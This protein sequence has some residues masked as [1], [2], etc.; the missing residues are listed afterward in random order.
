MICAHICFP[1]IG[2][3]PCLQISPDASAAAA[4]RLQKPLHIW[5]TQCMCFRDGWK[6][7]RPGAAAEPHTPKKNLFF[8]AAVRSNVLWAESLHLGVERICRTNRRAFLRSALNFFWWIRFFLFHPAAMQGWRF[9]RILSNSA[10]I[11]YSNEIK[12][13]R[14]PRNPSDHRSVSAFKWTLW[15]IF[16]GKSFEQTN[17]GAAGKKGKGVFLFWN[18]C[19]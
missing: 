9:G 7:W 15:C 16:A 1:C 8:R 10:F 19:S 3:H 6:V 17:P 5:R 18:L 4:T 14:I 13:E 12:W 2:R 11:S